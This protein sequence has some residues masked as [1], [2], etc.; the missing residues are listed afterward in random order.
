MALGPSALPHQLHLGLALQ[1]SQRV[2]P[3][4]RLVV[5]HQR[6]QPQAGHDRTAG[7]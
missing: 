3:G 6:A 2:A 5:H 4:Q 1:Q 7:R